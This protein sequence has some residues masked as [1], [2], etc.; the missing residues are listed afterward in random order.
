MTTDFYEVLGVERTATQVEI[1]KAYRKLALSHHPDKVPEELRA[2]SEVKFKEISAAYEVLS[3]ESKRDMYDNGGMDSG[4]GHGQGFPGGFDEEDFFSFFNGNGHA[5]GGHGYEEAP[6]QQS[7]RTE[8]A[9]LDVNVTLED[10]FKGK[11][12]KITS[13]RNIL[14]GGCSGRGLR[15]TARGNTCP[16]CNGQKYVKVMHRM[17]P[18]VFQDVEPCKRCEAQGKV[19][20]KSEKC[21]TCKGDKLQEQTKILEFVISPGSKFGDEVVL[22]GESDESPGKTTGDVILL[23]NEDKSVSSQFERRDRDLYTKVTFTLE[24]ALCGVKDKIL[25]KHLDGRYLKL[26]TPTGKV[27]RPNEYLK[28]PGEGFPIVNTSIRGDLYILIVVE[29][30]RDNWFIER[31]EVNRVRDVLPIQPHLDEDEFADI[32]IHNVDNIDRFFIVNEKNEE[33][34]VMENG[35]SSFCAQQ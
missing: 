30:P 27:L 29:F 18:M 23:I 6:M 9:R 17:G 33:F 28:I 34:R 13:T 20:K 22:K 25:L 24:E 2:E 35:R 32:D 14:C 19:Y 21:K 26:S 1:K 3:D 10:L 15:S 7:N 4:A 31:G 8:D 11:T 16:T 5:S 12:V